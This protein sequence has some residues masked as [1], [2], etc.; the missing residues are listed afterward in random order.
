MT[1]AETDP[2]DGAVESA[3]TEGAHQRVPYETWP[4]A[5]QAAFWAFHSQVR[6]RYLEWAYLQLGSDADA[7]EAVDATFDALTDK[8]DQ[9]LRMKNLPGYAW[10]VLKHR[11]VDQLRRQ[12][13]HAVPMDHAVFDA[14][15]A[16][17]TRDPFQDLTEAMVAFQELRRLPERQRDVMELCACLGFT[18][19][20]VAYLMGVERA[21][22]RSHIRQARQRLA[23]RL[24]EDV[25]G[26]EGEK[27]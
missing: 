23:Y 18:T 9:M 22:V 1:Q 10:T 11:V 21:T 6:T 3:V 26:P 5:W 17:R 16:T 12:G 19:E 25:E 8:W 13:R 15:V 2:E 14:A 20:E 27:Q 7:E 24:R 4:P